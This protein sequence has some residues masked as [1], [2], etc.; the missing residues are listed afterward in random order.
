MIFVIGCDGY[1]GNALTQ[2]L[3]NEG[4]NV[5]G[6]DNFWRRGW[7]KNDMGSTSATHLFKMGEKINRFRNFYRTKKPF[8]FEDIDV[9]KQDIYFD[10]CV[11]DYKPT[12]IINLAHNPSAP[13]S[14]KSKTNAQKVLNNNIIGTNNI[15]WSIKEHC[16]DC[17]YITI[18]TVGEYDHYSNIDIEEGFFSFRHKGRQSNKMMFPR[19]PGSIYHVSKA[20]STYLIDYLARAWNLKC[21]DVM[22]GIV[23]GA[24]T[25][26]IDKYHMYS[27]FDFDEAGGTVINRFVIQAILGIPLTIYGNG[28]H[29]RSFLSLNDS[30]QALMI[31]LNNPA[32]AG[33]VQTWNQLSEWHTMNDI[34]QMVIDVGN[35]FGLDTTA[36]WIDTPRAEYTGNH[37]YNFI[38]EKLTSKGYKPTRTIKEEIK[39]CFEVLYPYKDTLNEYRDVVIP[40]I[41]FKR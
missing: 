41:S 11:A 17:H 9:T 23:F 15:L 5:F 36:Q 26:E 33:E 31:A 30:V 1:I 12:A 35:E 19:R 7:I 22:Q 38:T 21:T 24:Y 2:R 37:Y 20:S 8:Y 39:Y 27:R 29:Q 16:P 32:E 34:S 18:G 10:Q 14:M 3:L 25:P 6:F 4:H 40:K 28:E 13:Y